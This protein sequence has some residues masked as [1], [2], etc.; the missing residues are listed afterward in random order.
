MANGPHVLYASSTPTHTNNGEQAQS[1]PLR[2]IA[3]LQV[4]LNASEQP[5]RYGFDFA[6]QRMLIRSQHRPFAKTAVL[7]AKTQLQGEAGD[8]HPAVSTP[9][10]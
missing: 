3:Y 1:V 7:Q 8:I 10:R 9:V 2:N 6:Q 5:R 4:F